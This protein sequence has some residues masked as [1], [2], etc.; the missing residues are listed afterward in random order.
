MGCFFIRF[1]SMS[2]F[3]LSPTFFQMISVKVA[4]WCILA[5]LEILNLFIIHLIWMGFVLNLIVRRRKNITESSSCSSDRF[6]KEKWLKG[7]KMRLA[8]NEKFWV[9]IWFFGF[10]SLIRLIASGRL[11]MS[12]DYFY[13]SLTIF[14]I[15][16]QK[17]GEN[18]GII[19]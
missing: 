19:L 15:S 10:F 14:K 7:L 11:S 3:L 13:L 9:F 12:T 4:K 1:L 8:G 18:V 5:D 16:G 6:Y 2:A 17:V